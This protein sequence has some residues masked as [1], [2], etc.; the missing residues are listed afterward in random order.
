[1]H[2]WHALVQGEPQQTPST[3]LPLAH[4][5]FD[6]QTAPCGCPQAPAPLQVDGDVHVPGSTIP[7]GTFEQV[8]SEPATLHAWHV[9][10]QDEL[11]HTPSTQ[12]PLVHWPPDV[13]TAP[14]DRRQTPDTQLPGAAHGIPQPPQLFASVPRTLVSQP[15]LAMPSQSPKPVLQA[16][17]A[18]TLAM[19]PC[20]A[21]LARAHAVPHAPQ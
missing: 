15:V 16:P 4:W 13:H 10:A 1:L 8:P 9:P 6:A 5:P 17:M 18:Q 12:L 19:H 14:L 7:A 20:V 3:Q 21:T 11:Q 2:A